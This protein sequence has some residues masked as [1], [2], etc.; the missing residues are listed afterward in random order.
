MK[1]QA[2]VKIK[3]QGVIYRFCWDSWA[4]ATFGPPS[5]TL[6]WTATNRQF[7]LVDQNETLTMAGKNPNRYWKTADYKMSGQLKRLESKP[8][9]LLKTLDGHLANMKNYL[10][11]KKTVSAEKAF[12]C[13]FKTYDE[14]KESSQQQRLLLKLKIFENFDSDTNRMLEGM[15]KLWGGQ[16]PKCPP[17]EKLKLSA[18]NSSTFGKTYCR[19]K[20]WWKRQIPF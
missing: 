14:L 10:A 8:A 12:K 9:E 16:L 5:R 19:H 7:K 15:S 6:T 17:S 11:Q 13:F 18:L 3:N 1:N 4:A 2:G 20:N